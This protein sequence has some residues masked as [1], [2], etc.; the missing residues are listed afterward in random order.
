MAKPLSPRGHDRQRLTRITSP[1]CGGEPALGLRPEG[2]RAPIRREPGGGKRTCD[3]TRSPSPSLPRKRGREENAACA[4]PIKPRAARN[5]RMNEPAPW[6]KRLGAGLRR[7][8]SAIGGAIADLVE[9]RPLDAK[10]LEELEDVL[11]RA[12]LGVGVAAR[13]AA[14]VG[15]GRYDKMVAP[16]EVKRILA[17]EVEKMLAPVAQPLGIGPQKPFVILVVGVNG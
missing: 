14:A 17:G 5:S 16:E 13:I 9:K 7:T 3:G 8:A 2:R 1:A 11:I 6:L 15:E 12:D 10:T 4:Q